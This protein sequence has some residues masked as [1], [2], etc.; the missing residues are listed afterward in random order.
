MQVVATEC[1]VVARS[2]SAN[3]AEVTASTGVDA[4]VRYTLGSGY[5]VGVD[6]VVAAAVRGWSTG[7]VLSTQ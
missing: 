6:A 5:D 7:R 2:R 4:H 1:G 3:W